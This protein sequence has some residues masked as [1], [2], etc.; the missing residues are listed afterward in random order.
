M[1]Y[2]N[3]TTVVSKLTSESLFPVIKSLGWEVQGGMGKLCKKSEFAMELQNAK[4]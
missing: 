1:C 4:F 2:N 3:L